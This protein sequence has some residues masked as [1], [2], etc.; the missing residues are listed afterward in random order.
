MV[1]GAVGC[2]RRFADAAVAADVAGAGCSA[3]RLAVGLLLS[4]LVLV[5]LFLVVLRLAR[6]SK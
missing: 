6:A 4:L 5:L 3:G 1:T 2:A